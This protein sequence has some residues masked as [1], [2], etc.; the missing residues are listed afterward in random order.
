MQEASVRLL[1]WP[2]ALTIYIEFEG[3]WAYTSQGTTFSTPQ[4]LIIAQEAD[5]VSSHCG[6]PG[7]GYGPPR[8]V[9]YADFNDPVPADVYRCQPSCFVQPQPF[10]YANLTHTYT[11]DL[12]STTLTQTA[13]QQSYMSEA[14]S[15]LCSTI[16][17]DYAPV[18]SIP[19][20]F[21]TLQPAGFQ[22]PGSMYGDDNPCN[23]IFNEDAVLFDPPQ[24]LTEAS[25]ETKPTLPNA[26][27]AYPTPT[28][29]TVGALPESLGLTVPREGPVATVYTDPKPS[30]GPAMTSQAIGDAIASVLGMT[31]K[32]GSVGSPLTLA[33]PSDGSA[34]IVNGVTTSISRADPQATGGGAQTGMIT[35]DGN[36]IGYTSS[37]GVLAIGGQTLSRGGSVVLTGKTSSSS[38][39]RH[40]SAAS[41]S[42][43]VETA[44]TTS[45]GPK[46][47]G[48]WFWWGLGLLATVM[49]FGLDG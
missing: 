12:G 37:D 21:K 33:M 32:E 4:T 42:Q 15:N 13:S 30:D 27:S 49:F 9:N 24:A 11:Y 20:A 19:P 31:S 28:E 44:T 2:V 5:A 36:A 16:W 14:P 7:G 41:K 29:T 1:Y 23:F 40:Q 43:T 34:I 3:S 46:L 38:I 47:S 48:H 17:N 25:E 45:G 6:K 35:V 18:L 10:T 39:T 26:N 22:E 8:K